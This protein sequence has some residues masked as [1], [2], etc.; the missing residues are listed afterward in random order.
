MRRTEVCAEPDP[1]GD[2]L[3][4]TAR[5]RAVAIPLE[6]VHKLVNE[7]ASD[8]VTDPPRIASDLSNV[9]RREMDLLVLLV[10][11]GAARMSYTYEW[12][13]VE[14]DG[15]DCRRS[16]RRRAVLGGERRWVERC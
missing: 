10:E 9:V 6:D 14:R 5:A 15:A 8:L 13:N 1:V 16:R 4:Y 11:V 7:H 3:Y 2:S 12:A